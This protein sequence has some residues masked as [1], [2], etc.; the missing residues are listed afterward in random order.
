[1][2]T[3]QIA[4]R[5]VGDGH[6]VF[7]VAECGINHNGSLDMAL[8]MIQ[9]AADSGVDA[10]KFQLFRAAGMYTPDAGLYRTAS[11][12]MVPIYA[13]M[14]DVELPL[15]W[16]P[17]LSAR[18]RELGLCF[19]MTVCD[20][21]C[22]EAVEQYDF[23]VYKIASYEI[24]HLPMLREISR[25]EMPVIMS[26][27]AADMSDVVEA[28]DVLPPNT[29]RPLGVL[30]CTAKYPAELSEI[31]L[32]VIDTFSRIFPNVVAGYS[33]HTEDPVQAPVQAV[34]HGAKIIEKHFT[35]DRELPG[36]DH[37][38]AL[39]PPDLR[40]MVSAIRE[41]ETTLE[42]G[43]YPE[44]DK[45]MAGSTFKRLTEAE[46][47][48]RDFAYRGIFTTRKIAAGDILSRDNLAVLRP[49]ELQQGLHP[50]Y[51]DILAS[52]RYV[53]TQGLEKY[54]GLQWDDVLSSR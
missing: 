40:R 52:G 36:A 41:A 17:T 2:A 3:L 11:G 8:Q 1:M 12:D 42:D 46:Q 4:D 6:A 14:E 19:I 34:Y 45:T 15:E 27:G 48:L 50:R 51:F 33:D 47:M 54:R 10:V 21:W 24:S 16:I 13:L 28:V 38:F 37:C 30:Q 29:E 20:E 26:T 32:S 53:A 9:K 35:L 31:N 22:V 43:N 39:D 18:C 44:L 5:N 25:R 23:D 7:I 49:G